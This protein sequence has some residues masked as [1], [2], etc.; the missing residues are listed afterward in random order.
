MTI[1]NNHLTSH[2]LADQAEWWSTDSSTKE[3]E[4]ALN[5]KKSQTHAQEQTILEQSKQNSQEQ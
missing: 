1:Q 2:P 5:Q 4:A 3:A